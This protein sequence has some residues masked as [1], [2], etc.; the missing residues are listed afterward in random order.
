MT[1]EQIAQLLRLLEKIADRP[2]TI[3]QASDWPLFVFLSAIGFALLGLMWRDIGQKLTS[4]MASADSSL[5]EHK[6]DNVR[7]YDKIWSAL[8]D[9]QEDCCITKTPH[10]GSNRREDGGK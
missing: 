3:T 2:F 6:A 9:C 7:E 8:R 4:G 1:T 10:R 5:A